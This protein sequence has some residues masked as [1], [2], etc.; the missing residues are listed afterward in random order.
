MLVS[1]ATFVK[2]IFILDVYEACRRHAPDFQIECLELTRGEREAG[3]ALIGWHA[4]RDGAE[5]GQRTVVRGRSAV[6]L[7]ALA[8][9]L[10]EAD[11]ILSRVAASSSPG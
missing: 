9:F 6:H 11:V 4:T 10:N 3:L 7:I 5:Y 1:F 2:S 8:E